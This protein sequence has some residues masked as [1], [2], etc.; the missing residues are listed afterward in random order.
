MVEKEVKNI[1][2]LKKEEEEEATKI[3]LSKAI[4]R[5]PKDALSFNALDWEELTVSLGFI[6]ETPIAS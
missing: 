2:A 3:S 1:K 6:L 5:S 4:I